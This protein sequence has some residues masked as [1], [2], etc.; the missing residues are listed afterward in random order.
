LSC[1]FLLKSHRGHRFDPNRR[2]G[3]RHRR[4]DAPW[5]S[6]FDASGAGGRHEIDRVLVRGNSSPGKRSNI[7][8]VKRRVPPRRPPKPGVSKTK[9]WRMRL[10]R[11]DITSAQDNLPH[12][13]GKH[14]EERK[15]VSPRGRNTTS[16]GT[17]FVK[18][19][20]ERW[21]E[22]RSMFFQDEIKAEKHPKPGPPLDLGEEEC[23]VCHRHSPRLVMTPPYANHEG[24][25]FSKANGIE[26]D[27]SNPGQ[28]GRA[29]GR[30]RAGRDSPTGGPC[31]NA[32][33]PLIAPIRDLPM[34]ISRRRSGRGVGRHHS[35]RP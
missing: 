20:P 15:G 25:R 7:A 18:K 9:T 31:R 17:R 12:S 29:K 21:S 35:G 13:G 30:A 32:V 6:I 22:K 3:S 24:R 14:S 4:K 33:L 1:R 23:Q 26:M 5:T 11:R 19:H 16:S 28:E 8:R 2:F 27:S 10:P 34:T